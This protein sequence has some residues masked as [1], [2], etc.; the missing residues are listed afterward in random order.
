MA[1]FNFHKRQTRRWWY[2]G[3]TLVA[4]AFFAVVLVGGASANLGLSTFEGNDGNLNLNTA[5]NI[6]W[7]SLTTSGSPALHIGSE[8]FSG[9]QDNSFGQGTKEDKSAVTLVQGSIPPNKS[10]LTVFY[11]ASQQVPG[12][13]TNC[14][15]APSPCA[16]TFIYLAWERSNVL[17]SANMDFEINKTGT[18][19]MDS[20]GPFPVKCT[21]NRTSGDVL[22]TYDFSNGGGTPNVGLRTWNG[23]SW[24]TSTGVV[25][26]SAVNDQTVVDGVTESPT[27][28]TSLDANEFGEASIDLT[29]SNV[30]S[31][32]DCGFG[33]ATTFLK[34]RS[35]ASFTSEIK[36]YIAP[37]STPLVQC[38]GAIKVVKEAKNKNCTGAGASGNANTAATSCIAASRQALAGASFSIWQDTNS[39][40]GLQTTDNEGTCQDVADTQVGS[41]AST[42]ITGSGGS[43]VASACFSD[44]TLGDYFVHEDSAPSGFATAADKTVTVAQSTCA[45]GAA[46][47]NYTVANNSADLPLTNLTVTAASVLQGA[48]NSRISCTSGGTAIS[49]SPA[50]A[51]VNNV[52][53]FA[54][55]DT[56]TSN[57]LKPGTYNCTVVIDP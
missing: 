43:A 20:T 55:P 27:F 40:A 57:G 21:I 54:D 28:N 23:S 47:A 25:A 45:S 5:G 6:D 2:A 48:S 37:V 26:E 42:A 15:T 11:E 44:L 39:C 18:P 38:K 9:T 10:D 30:V 50:P 49:G 17:G 56:L 3:V 8:A 32:G 4:V 24:Q 52:Q 34:S 53:Q 12:Y 31:S 13:T 7:N 33:Q 46:A 51:D 16:H 1:A 29:A 41:S 22:V 19:C 36:D 35:A 14:G